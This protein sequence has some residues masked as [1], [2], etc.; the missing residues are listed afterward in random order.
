[1]ISLSLFLLTVGLSDVLASGLAVH[2]LTIR[3]ALGTISAASLLAA[4]VYLGLGA[5]WEHAL[6]LGALVLLS[7][8]AWLGL[9]VA[10]MHGLALLALGAGISIAVIGN[11]LLGGQASLGFAEPYLVELPWYG[12]D[13]SIA[14]YLVV[15][16]V[17][18]FLGATAN[19][20]VRSVLLVASDE[21]M[22]E[23][24][25]SRLRG[26]RFIGVLERYLIFGLAFAGEPTAAALV[27]SAK[28]IVRF[29]ELSARSQP[30]PGAPSN[31]NEADEITEY[32]LLG[33]LTSWTLALAPVVLLRA[34]PGPG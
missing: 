8:A 5:S 29:P 23:R 21:S 31:L 11:T 12:H 33:S 30:G 34:I 14:F 32:F 3:R 2:R 26:G 20:V 15:A 13:R 1:M 9:R 18:V 25:E 16:S 22:L 19:G 10:R 27:I 7:V 4:L 28:S 24:S 17:M 6:L